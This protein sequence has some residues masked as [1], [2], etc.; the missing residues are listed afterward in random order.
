MLPRHARF[1]LRYTETKLVLAGGNDPPTSALSRRCSATELRE[2]RNGSP[3]RLRTTDLLVN[4]Q[5]LLPTELSGN[6]LVPRARLER[7]TS[8]FVDRRSGILLS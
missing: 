6:G 1:Q 8:G 3:T 2:M 4:S 7:A 5:A